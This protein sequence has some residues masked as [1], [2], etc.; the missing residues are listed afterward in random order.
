M[1]GVEKVVRIPIILL[2]QFDDEYLEENINDAILE[3]QLIPI[4]SDSHIR[5]RDYGDASRNDF[6]KTAV[7]VA[8]VIMIIFGLIE[9]IANGVLLAFNSNIVYVMAG[10]AAAV[11][12]TTTGAV[13]IAASCT[14]ED[15]PIGT[16]ML[17]ATLTSLT[18]AGQLGISI[19]GILVDFLG[20]TALGVTAVNNVV[21][22]TAMHGFNGLAAIIGGI[23]S[24]V[25]AARTCCTVCCSSRMF[26]Y[27][28][29]TLVKRNESKP[30]KPTLVEEYDEVDSSE[31]VYR[32]PWP[33]QEEF[34]AASDDMHRPRKKD[35]LDLILSGG[36]PQKKVSPE[37]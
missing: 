20:S 23:C 1:T 17:F 2:G 6:N 37:Y 11:F 19:I 18:S 10:C 12:L 13:G 14:L 16:T 30:K 28:G 24:I 34:R 22:A 36:G 35:I 32:S 15:C 26:L 33:T 21:G 8:S 9:F 3:G 27:K 29:M 25:V 31:Y 5:R 4:P 7:L